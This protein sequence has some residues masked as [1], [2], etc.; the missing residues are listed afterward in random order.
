MNTLNALNNAL[1]ALGFGVVLNEDEGIYTVYRLFSLGYKAFE[2]E[3]FD[4][5]GFNLLGFFHNGYGEVTPDWY[6]VELGEF[7]T[8][9]EVVEKIRLT[10]ETTQMLSAKAEAI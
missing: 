7:D 5:E 2:I 9:A 3:S 1:N 4:D 6:G 8:I 10:F